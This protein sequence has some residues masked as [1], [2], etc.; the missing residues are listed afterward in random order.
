MVLDHRPPRGQPG[1]QA[2]LARV[3][4]LDYQAGADFAG[5]EAD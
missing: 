2:V 4:V 1:E 3:G 5:H